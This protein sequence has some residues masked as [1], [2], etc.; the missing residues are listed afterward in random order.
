MRKIFAFILTFSIVLS[1]CA[2]EKLDI[3]NQSKL[4]EI[5][6]NAGTLTKTYNITKPDF[7]NKSNRKYNH[8]E[9]DN[10][11]ILPF[12]FTYSPLK[13]LQQQLQQ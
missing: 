13:L 2:Q 1:C 12:N 11:T 9:D 8:E 7:D 3:K 5:N 4:E 10:D 6:L